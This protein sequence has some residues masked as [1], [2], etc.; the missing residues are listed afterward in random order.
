MEPS[1]ACIDL[2]RDSEGFS[3]KPYDNDGH[4][5]IGYGST[6]YADGR[7]VTMSDPPID[8]PTARALMLDRLANEYAPQVRKVVKVPLTQGQFDAVVDF[9]YNEGIGRLI[10][11]TLLR[12]LNAGHY[13]AAADEFPRWVFQGGKELPGLVKRRARERAMF[14]GQA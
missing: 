14:L 5:T 8:E 3:A 11:S 2:I 1:D 10:G 4:P 12:L 7:S 6:Y 9:A 13:A